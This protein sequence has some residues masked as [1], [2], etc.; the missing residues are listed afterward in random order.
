MNSNIIRNIRIA[1]HNNNS[2]F[3]KRWIEYCENNNLFYKLVDIYSNS[4]VKD[5]KDCQYIF[6]HHN[7]YNHKD[8]LFAKSILF[9]FEH[10]GKIVFPDFFTGWHFD[11]K[12]GQ[13]YLLESLDV[14]SVPTYIFYDKIS[15]LNW[16]ESTN[17]PKVF[18]LR[19]G[20]GSSNV[21]LI[22]N[23]KKGTKVI[24]IAFS[25]GFYK[26]Q[27]LRSVNE[28][29]RKYKLGKGS[30]V[31]VVKGFIRLLIMP[32]YSALSGVERQYV[33]FQDFIPSLDHDIRVIVI[34]DR[35]FAIKRMVRKNDFRASGSGMILYERR[36]IPVDA[37]RQSFQISKQLQS[38]CLAID[39][40]YFNSTPLVLE[41][42]Y[43][44]DTH[45]YDNCPGF[46]DSNLKWYEGTFNPQGWMIEYAISTQ[47]SQ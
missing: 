28:R 30:F 41:V 39:Y 1:I 18:K 7:H 20:A 16:I 45:V 44:F 40:V 4:I 24:N 29:I 27:K 38:K 3:T 19:S 31:D 47:S 8:I 35:A 32:G 43:G 34:G 6:I 15:A 25:K 33:Y 37:I 22:K 2:G 26:Y 36:N 9:S 23:K 5:V 10:S 42:S 12:I 13:K 14:P 46:W 21:Q 11:D 17:F